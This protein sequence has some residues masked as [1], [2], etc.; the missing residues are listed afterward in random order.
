MAGTGCKRPLEVLLAEDDP[1]DIRLFKDIVKQCSLN[2]N[3]HFVA[4]GEAAILFLAENE[5]FRD[6]SRPRLI[7]L[8]LNMPKKNGREVLA[9]IKADQHL[10]SIPVVIFTTSSSERDAK[11]CYELQAASFITKPLGR[12][13]FVN[14]IVAIDT[15][16]ATIVTL[17]K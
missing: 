5:Y 16:W 2:W 10:K 4:D 17:P 14:T 7:L 6:P 1:S 9:E 11:E 8:D 15:Y 3:V 12:Q 13:E